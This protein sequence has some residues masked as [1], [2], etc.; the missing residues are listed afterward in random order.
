MFKLLEVGGK[1][2]GMEDFKSVLLSYRN[3]F[4]Y[5]SSVYTRRGGGVDV[6]LSSVD[7]GYDITVTDTYMLKAV[8]E[9]GKAVAR[10]KYTKVLKKIG[11]TDEDIKKLVNILSAIER[12]YEIWLTK[13]F[14]EHYHEMR[15]RNITTSCMAREADYYELA[16]VDGEPVHPLTPFEQS[17]NFYLALA[18]SIGDD[19]EYPWIARSVVHREDE[20][21]YARATWYG[22]E[23][24]KLALSKAIPRGWSC[25][26]R[27]PAIEADCGGYVAP[28][29]DCGDGWELD[30][31]YLVEG[32]SQCEPDTGVILGRACE[33]CCE[34]MDEGSGIYVAGVGDVCEHC[35]DE[36]VYIESC[37]DYRHV[38]DCFQCK[39]CHEW[40]LTYH[41]VGCEHCGE[42]I[43]EDCC[44]DHSVE[45]IH[46]DYYHFCSE[47]CKMDHIEE[48]IED[49]YEEEDE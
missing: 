31:E 20:D 16:V 28:Y 42:D 34:G 48:N 49:Y 15:K 25:D 43:C 27:I 24:A 4:T 46:G 13:D 11:A 26:V 7:T 32:E 21:V 5:L 39:I 12:G 22:N 10:G 36:Y 33:H 1:K 17:E 14:V 41:A 35:A 40:H 9:N 29:N 45:D 38:E 47:E 19:S 6:A 8:D 37:D 3:S 44:N 23:A 18:K 30:G 2:V